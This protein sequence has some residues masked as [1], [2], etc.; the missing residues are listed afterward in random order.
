MISSTVLALR[1]YALVDLSLKRSGVNDPD[2]DAQ[3]SAAKQHIFF[4]E[5]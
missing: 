2:N 5:R 4:V 1:L 3:S